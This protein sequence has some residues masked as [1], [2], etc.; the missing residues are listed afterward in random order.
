[1]EGS[2]FSASGTSVM[3]ASVVSRRDAIEA[4]FCRATRSTLVGSMIPACNMSTYSLVSASKPRVMGTAA[5]TFSTTTEPSSPAFCTI[6]RMGSS[7]ARRTM[8][9]PVA[10]SPESLRLPR[11]YDARSS[12]TPPWH[13]PLLDGGPRGVEGVLDPRL[14]LFHLGLGGRAYLD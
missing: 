2:A 9:T 11:A 6:C 7:R 1:M 8:L 5:L 12:A 10:S 14:L 13:D 3:S 4:A